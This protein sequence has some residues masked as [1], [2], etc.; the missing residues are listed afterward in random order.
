MIRN[1]FKIA[2]RNLLKNR[3]FSFINIFGLAIGMTVAILNGLWIWDEL[4][5]NK[6]HQNYDRITHV[7]THGSYKGEEYLN[8]TLSLPLA[9]EIQQNYKESFQH[10]VK[11]S[12][13]EDLIL[14]AGDEKLSRTGQ[15]MD[16]DAPDMLT[17]KM[18]YGSRTGL[19]DPYSI[20]LSAST[21]KG[22]FGDADPID[23]IVRINNK[24]NVKVTGVYED[25][26]LNSHFTKVKFLAPWKLWEAENE[27]ISKRAVSEWNNHFLKLFAEVKPGL[28]IEQATRRLR[29]AELKYQANYEMAASTKPAVL[30][31]P[32]SKWH[33]YT[34]F[35]NGEAQDQ[36]LRFVWM[37]GIVGLFVLLLA[38]I[39][40]M[41]LSTARSA[42]RAKEVG[43]RKA[44]GSVRWQLVN[45]FFSESLLIAALAFVLAVLFVNL[46]LPWF[47]NL[48]AKEIAMP[49]TNPWF[50]LSCLS[51]VFITGL[52]AGSYPALYLSSFQPVKVL[53]GTFRAGRFA[54]I[55][56]KTLVVV[57]FT[58][59]MILAI[60]TMIVYRQIQHAKDRPVGYTRD[61]LLMVEMKSRDFY[62]KHDLLSAELKRTGVVAELSAS[63]GKVTE[64]ASG[65]NGFTWKGK[66]TADLQSFGT[67]VVTPEYGKT[68]GWQ[69]IGGRDFSKAFASDS[70][71]LVIN[72]TAA[73]SMGLKDPVGETV[74]WSWRG[75]EIWQYRIL[76]VV[77]DMV[78]ESPYDPIEPTFF[79]LKAPN[80]SFNYL[81]IK[82]KPTVSMSQALPKIAAVFKTL[83]PAAPFDYNFA[84]QDYA[85][86]FAA[87]ER[88]EKLAGFFAILAIFISCLGLFGLATF[89]AE[90]RTKEI[91]IRKVLG[92]SVF[93]L[94]RLLSKDFVVL[95]LLSCM[96]AIP[97]AAYL[98]GKWL[99]K[100]SYRTEIS[101]WIFAAACMG[102]LLITLLTVSFQSV[103][104]ALTDPVK[105]LRTE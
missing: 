55:P 27:W 75:K 76:G 15:F 18:V 72:E 19:M 66:D 45:Q 95:V 85:L 2:C 32:M 99:E 91:G 41:N 11:A 3:V 36:P 87:E 47:N 23:R 14:A 102:A 53:K 26:P 34:D 84:D 105:S 98:L 86:K 60:S 38:C 6:Y 81:N 69:F 104:A 40:F 67:L 46:L 68:V 63:M 57:Q 101:W 33:L 39:N 30:L 31:Q 88:I 42:N 89:M 103:K 58:V 54:A 1:Y 83:I 77:K 48:A 20:M 92:A 8:S 80:G 17:L 56:R 73:R 7:M 97:V 29:G 28:S 74:R 12:W 43:I 52:L 94:W 13:V 10:I 49:W 37:V 22:L 61:G 44:I 64:I 4:S 51:F 62:G 59:S 82:V 21:A 35:R 78:M 25:L 71:G 5:F 24:T 100:Y 93:N 50:W 96:I 65:N 79:F 70:A 9:L 16:Q 90:Q